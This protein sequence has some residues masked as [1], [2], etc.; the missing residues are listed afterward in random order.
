M[1]SHGNN[2]AKT[3][4]ILEQPFQGLLKHLFLE[5]LRINDL[6]VDLHK[7]Q[8]HSTRALIFDGKIV[9]SPT[10]D[11]QATGREKSFTNI[12]TRFRFLGL[13]SILRLLSF[14]CFFA[15]V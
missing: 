2:S 9:A 3:R 13:P 12:T 10:V 4:L 6:R 1:N 7:T 11:W 15:H 14:I 5:K 8:T